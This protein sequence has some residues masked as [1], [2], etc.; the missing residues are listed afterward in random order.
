MHER[1]DPEGLGSAVDAANRRF[2]EA[3][4]TRDP[5]AAASG[6]AANARLL[7]P[8]AD[9]IE[10]RAG[11]ESFWRAGLD[12]GIRAVDRVPIRIEGRGSV[13]FEIGRYAIRLR[14]PDGG[15]VVD[16]GTYLLVHERAADGRWAWALETFT[17]EGSPQVASRAAGGTE[18]EVGHGE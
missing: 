2:V 7:A 13:A 6:Y 14:A 8:S 15:S 16:R 12:A 18:R 10:G 3:I 4:R 5:G 9:L 1:T 11:I 17:P